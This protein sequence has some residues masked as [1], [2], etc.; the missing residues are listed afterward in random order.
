MVDAAVSKTVAF[1]GRVGSNPTF[2]ISLYDEINKAAIVIG[3]AYG[4][5]EAT[6]HRL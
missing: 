1:Y 5:R 2:G 4:L 3:G 6:L